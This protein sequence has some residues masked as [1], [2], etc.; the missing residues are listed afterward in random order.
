MTL[1]TP[2]FCPLFARGIVVEGGGPPVS[3]V[4]LSDPTNGD[5]FVT[6]DCNIR[7]F[8]DLRFLSFKNS[9]IGEGR[10]FHSPVY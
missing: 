9:I 7:V 2:G 5:G 10:T 6:H 1:A 3:L 4:C 8:A